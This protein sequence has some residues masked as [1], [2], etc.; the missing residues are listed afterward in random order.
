V[1]QKAKD[2]VT[3]IL[4]VG[5]NI[6]ELINYRNNLEAMVEKRTSEL[7]QALQKEKELVE[8]KS[9]FVSV[10]SHE[11][12]TPLSTISLAAESV[13]NHFHQLGA[14]DIK[15]KLL[16][17]EDQAA[18]MTNLLEDVLTMGKSDAG[19][20]KVKLISLD[21]HEFVTTL[22]DEVRSVAKVPRTID[23]KFTSTLTTVSLDDK[24][25]RNV[26]VNLLTNAIKFSPEDSVVSVRISDTSEGIEISVEDQG[27]GIDQEELNTVF[28][29][30]HRGSNASNIQGTG[31]GLSITK[32]AVDLMRGTIH[33]DSVLNKGTTF[34]VKLPIR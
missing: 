3:G 29:A 33:V 16:K 22:I 5:Q 1:A 11:F 23:L 17:I 25:F 8:M 13:R 26:F 15:R 32:K 31:L 6:T 19:K 20:I 9:K 24:L 30:F 12:R 14:D 4:M 2:E 10:A 27:I 34:T 28:E 18:H 21:L 7:N